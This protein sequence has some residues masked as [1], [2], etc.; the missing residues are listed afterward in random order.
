[1][2]VFVVSGPSFATLERASKSKLRSM[3]QLRGWGS[4][5]V[6]AYL[7]DVLASDWVGK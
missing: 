6:A 7:S 1:M 2:V 5:D 4:R 3:H